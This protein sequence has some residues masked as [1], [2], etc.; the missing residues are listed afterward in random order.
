MGLT[1][2]ERKHSSRLRLYEVTK[3]D[4]RAQTH[5]HTHMDCYNPPPTLGLINSS[6][7]VKQQNIIIPVLD[8]IAKS[9]HK[10]SQ[11][12]QEMKAEVCHLKEAQLELREIVE[13]LQDKESLNI[14]KYKVF[15]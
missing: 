8:Y 9:S 11:V 12:L 15:K 1:G 10:Q 7:Q 14:D 13:N 6:S 3:K 2:S 5:T 4:S